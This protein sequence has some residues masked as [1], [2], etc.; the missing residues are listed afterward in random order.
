MGGGITEGLK[1]EAL[2]FHQNL[3]DKSKLYY[4]HSINYYENVDCSEEIEVKEDQEDSISSEVEVEN[5]VASN[6]QKNQQ[7]NEYMLFDSIDHINTDQVQDNSCK[8]LT[9]EI[10]KKNYNSN[11]MDPFIIERN[12]HTENMVESE[13]TPNPVQEICS[14]DR[15]SKL[16][17]MHPLMDEILQKIKMI[18]LNKSKQNLPVNESLEETYD[19]NKQHDK[20]LYERDLFVSKPVSFTEKTKLGSLDRLY[21]PKQIVHINMSKLN[22]DKKACSNTINN[23]K[24]KSLY[25]LKLPDSKGKSGLDQTDGLSLSGKSSLDI[26]RSYKQTNFDYLGSLRST[27]GF[28]L[29]KNEFGSIGLCNTKKKDYNTELRNQNDTNYRFFNYK[30]C[31]SSDGFK[32]M[33]SNNHNKADKGSNISLSLLKPI[34]IKNPN[35]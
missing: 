20:N 24:N 17:N 5:N 35:K 27:T 7:M 22:P 16:E 15:K 8:N 28:G 21:I 9:K 26:D 30:Y 25:S 34:T 3:L 11:N 13:N 2:R 23:Y 18:K 12:I 31:S 33:N 29:D 4:K 32:S 1:K 19:Y 6:Q 14:P 10:P